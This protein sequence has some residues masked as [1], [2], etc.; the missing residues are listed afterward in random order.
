[1]AESEKRLAT[2]SEGGAVT[3]Q[4]VAARLGFYPMMPIH[5]LVRRR[6]G[7]SWRISFFSFFS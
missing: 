2:D 7:A 5:G 6:P 1:M 4:S 3:K